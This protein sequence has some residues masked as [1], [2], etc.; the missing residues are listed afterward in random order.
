MTSNQKPQNIIKKYR[1]TILAVMA[2]AVALCCIFAFAGNNNDSG[3]NDSPLSYEEVVSQE[4]LIS[5]EGIYVDGVFIAAVN[6]K[7][8]AENVIAAA[9]SARVA[10]LGIDSSFENG[11]TNDIQI[12]SG[13]YVEQ[14]FIGNDKLLSCLNKTNLF[15]MSANIS[16]YSG[17]SLSIK[18]S[19]RS[20]ATYVE[21]IV[22]EHSVKTIYTDAM[23]DGVKNVVTQ[24]FDGEGERTYNVISIDGAV[25]HEE[26]VSLNVTTEPIDE[27]VRVGSRSNGKDVVSLGTF[28]KPYE[29]IITSYFGSRWG[30]NHDGLDIWTNDCAGKPAYAASNGVVVRADVY[31]GY[32]NCVIIDH[33]NGLKTLYAHLDSISVKVGDK[34]SAGDEVG[35]IGNTGASQ[36]AHLHFEVLVD[37]EKVN[38]L[39]F[40]EY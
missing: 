38:P 14:A 11:F 31:G 40:V 27:V 8:D 33:G 19:V 22:L 39:I 34:L 10:A 6:D 23:R 29:G 15:G 2:F 9:L 24:G 28:I 21:N 35:K 37:G 5:G 20:V 12:V 3:A 18:L 13:E 16:D 7:A 32:G 17:K 30:R 26:F 4:T 36:G 1:I 25:S